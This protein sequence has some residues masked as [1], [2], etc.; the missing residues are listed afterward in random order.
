MRGPKLGASIAL[1]A[2]LWMG[3]SGQLLAEPRIGLGEL[4]SLISQHPLQ[5]DPK[6][7]GK[8][9]ENFVA[10]RPVGETGITTFLIPGFENY[11]CD[12]CHQPEQLVQKAAA[13]MKRVLDRLKETHPESNQVPLRQYIIQP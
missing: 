5:R 4:D 12:K 8:K 2:A 9:L 3:G 1:A 7:T 10:Q 13:R 6:L 11:N